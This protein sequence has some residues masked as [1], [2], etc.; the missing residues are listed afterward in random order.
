MRVWLGRLALL[1][2]KLAEKSIFGDWEVAINEF[3]RRE[4]GGA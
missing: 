1:E 3:L 4:K 2:W